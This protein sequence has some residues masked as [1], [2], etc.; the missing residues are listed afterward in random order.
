MDDIVSF[1]YWVRRR[2]KALDLTRAALAQRV[3][4]A[5]VTIK[6]IEL[7]ERRPS[8]QMAE[9]LAIHLA[10][11]G[12]EQ[13]TF[14][15]MARGE[16]VAA[17]ASPL[18]DV[19]PLSLLDGREKP[20]IR[21]KA[22][23]VAREHELAQLDGFLDLALSDQPA[24]GS[25]LRGSSVVPGG[26]V[27]FVIGEAGTGKTALV[28]EFSRRV[29]ESVADLIVVGGH[30]HAY[31]GVGD[32]YLPFREVLGLLTGDVEA[33]LAAGALGREQ[34]RRLWGL[35]PYTVQALVKSGPDL[36]DIFVPGSTL[37][38]RAAVAASGGS[39]W[40][41]QL[42]ELVARKAA[43]QS[44][45]NLQQ[46]DLF[47]QYTRVLQALA[48]HAP[49]VLILDDLQWAD[50]GS[51]NMLFHLG[52]RLEG[53][54]L[55]IIGIYRP[56]D[57]A[58]GRDG[59]RHPLEPVVSEFRRHFG[60][61]QV[62]LRQTAARQFVDALLD[63]EP[64]RL[65]AKFR[66]ALYRYARGHALFTVEALRSMKE[67]EDLV[68]DEGGRWI[69]GPALDWETLP[70]RVEGVIGERINRLPATLQEV[71]KVASVEGEFF[72]AE[73]LARVLTVGEPAMVHQL[74]S[75]LDRQHRL[76]KSQSSQRMGSTGQRLSHY[77][78]RHIL[79]QRYLYTNLDDIERA[80]LHEAVGAVLEDLHQGQ[81][82]QVAGQLARHFEAAG[83]TEKAID[84][85]RQAGERAVRLSAHE[86]AVAL[87]TGALRLL[88]TLPDPSEHSQLELDLRI[89]LGYASIVFKG[90]AAPEV[91][92]AFARARELSYQLEETPQLFHLLWGLWTFWLIRGEIHPTAREL[93]EQCLRMAQR[94]R[95][96]TLLLGAYQALGT[97][98][99]FVGE[100]VPAQAHLEQ[101]ITLYDPQQSDALI[102]QYGQDLGVF[103]LRYMCLVKWLLGYPEQAL[104]QGD[105]ALALARQLAHPFSLAG[106]LAFDMFIHY[107]CREEQAVEERAEECITL[108]TK[109][110]FVLWKLKGMMFRGWTLTQR[111]Q[112][113]EGI[114]QIRQDL[115]AYCA[116][117]AVSLLLLPLL[118]IEAHLR[119]GQVAEG[120]AVL[121]KT[122]S[123]IE[124]TGEGTIEAELYRLKGELLRMGGANEGEVE[125]CFRQAIKI[126][127]R[128]SAKAWELRAT[129]SLSR[130]WQAHG[131][132]EEARQMLAEIYGW[133]TEGFDTPDLKEAKALLQTLTLA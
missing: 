87:F 45:A 106:A 129:V 71:L 10:I 118:L 130:L 27:V 73:V 7:D 44:P 24:P 127:R 78:F 75:E 47:E 60:Q 28:G 67:R 115:A 21:E 3:G 22:V 50:T 59:E 25:P 111:G 37:V 79:F 124:K 82:E 17:M 102:S 5:E 34:A 43:T 35:I 104:E 38:K 74:S 88:D 85:L 12:A 113:E 122:F 14:F 98:L 65:G 77:R 86:E 108:S 29:Q 42:E 89:A 69:E 58:L 70:A 48:Q 128:Q 11:P 76:V 110:G 32:P 92:R 132:K 61:I 125:A 54:H 109:H 105:Q 30:C 120:L 83:L 55:L 107:F 68:Q 64:N 23:F 93:A 63:T 6:K 40:R 46:S 117:G 9:L 16:F 33:R 112:L 116:T 123:E 51:I 13:D 39:G 97:T 1:G 52:R 133:F 94:L 84:Y 114:E 15:R 31:T 4:C 126:A 72:T 99:S 80:Y 100:L 121:E 81:T 41:S 91:G 95:D 36:I 2:R 62:D 8:R 49:L 53:S 19:S 20:A 101:M 96:P 57:V 26:R 90:S 66:D 56:A 18:A 119:M 131:K 103:C